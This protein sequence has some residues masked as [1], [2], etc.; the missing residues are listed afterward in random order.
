MTLDTQPFQAFLVD[1]IDLCALI[2]LLLD[3]RTFDAGI[4]FNTG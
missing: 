4:N 2:A 3:L 1:L